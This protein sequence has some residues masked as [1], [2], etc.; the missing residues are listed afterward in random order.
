MPTCNG[1][2]HTIFLA[3]ASCSCAISRAVAPDN[4]KLVCRCRCNICCNGFKLILMLLPSPWGLRH[5]AINIFPLVY[6]KKNTIAVEFGSCSCWWK[7]LRVTM[8]QAC[9]NFFWIFSETEHIQIFSLLSTI[10]CNKCFFS[11]ILN[12]TM[13]RV[14]IIENDSCLLQA[15]A[16]L[17]LFQYR[18]FSNT[19][20]PRCCITAKKCMQK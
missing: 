13:S 17:E 10:D 19:I 20:N 1:A 7:H 16:V 2:A 12:L 6:L 18:S 5:T 4:F 9:S 14:W 8:G 3:G 15:Y 11:C